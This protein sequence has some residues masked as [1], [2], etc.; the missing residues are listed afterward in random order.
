MPDWYHCDLCGDSDYNND[1]VHSQE[2]M[3]CDLRLCSECFPKEATGL[4]SFWMERDFERA[5]V[6]RIVKDFLKQRMRSKIEGYDAKTDPLNMRG[7]S[8]GIDTY[9]ADDL[10]EIGET[11]FEDDFPDPFLHRYTP[12][13]V[14]MGRDVTE[15]AMLH[16]LLRKYD[17]T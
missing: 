11:L 16:Y 10:D 6:I 8:R 14:C 1:E 17:M 12:R 15:G 3:Y 9:S 7:L 2:C 4:M 5:N 13:N